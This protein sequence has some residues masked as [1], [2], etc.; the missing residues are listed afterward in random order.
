MKEDRRHLEGD[1]E[2]DFY[3]YQKYGNSKTSI[4]YDLYESYFNSSN[5]WSS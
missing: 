4:I 3:K 5:E 2:N 1:R